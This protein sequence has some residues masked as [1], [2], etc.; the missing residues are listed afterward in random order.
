MLSTLKEKQWGDPITPAKCGI[1]STFRDKFSINA[2]APN[3]GQKA[4]DDV[5][6]YHSLE[7]HL[8]ITIEQGFDV[9]IFML[10]ARIY[11]HNRKDL[12]GFIPYKLRASQK[13]TLEYSSANA[14]SVR[15]KVAWIKLC[16]QFPLQI[17][18]ALI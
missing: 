3:L 9:A 18:C 8:V 16:G 10:S 17:H 11:G 6:L 12:S 1:K 5:R 15:R 4:L 13:L 7:N 2:N 14:V